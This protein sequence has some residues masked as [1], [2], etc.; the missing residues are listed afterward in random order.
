MGTG[1]HRNQKYLSFNEDMY[2][3]LFV[4]LVKPIFKKY[5][6]EHRPSDKVE[7]IFKM[8]LPKLSDSTKIAGMQWRELR[9]NAMKE[10]Y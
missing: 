10:N 6:E 9:T 7:K 2:S 5:C 8:V 4:S 3:L 1:P